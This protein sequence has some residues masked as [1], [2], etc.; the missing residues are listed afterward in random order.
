MPVFLNSLPGSPA[1]ASLNF[2]PR[3]TYW[4]PRPLENG[5]EAKANLHA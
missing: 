2:K 5:V 3:P 4:R 1:S